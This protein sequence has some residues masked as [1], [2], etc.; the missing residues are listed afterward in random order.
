MCS[1]NEHRAVD[2]MRNTW[3]KA[4]PSGD[5]QHEDRPVAGM[6]S[7]C[8][9]SDDMSVIAERRFGDV[10]DPLLVFM[11]IA[12]SMI[13]GNQARLLRGHGVPI[14]RAYRAAAPGLFWCAASRYTLMHCPSLSRS[15]AGKVKTPMLRKLFRVICGLYFSGPLSVRS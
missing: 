3:L 9:L 12:P 1:A 15:P 4:N 10:N 13:V 5:S 8:S 14:G 7:P 2:L 11:T 6:T